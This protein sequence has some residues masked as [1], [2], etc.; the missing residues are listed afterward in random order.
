[1]SCNEM[2]NYGELYIEICKFYS[3]KKNKKKTNALM[4]RLIMD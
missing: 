1:M 2:S 4:V 3:S